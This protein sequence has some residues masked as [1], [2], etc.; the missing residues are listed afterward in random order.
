MHQ[1]LE[2]VAYQGRLEHQPALAASDLLDRPIKLVVPFAP[3]GATDI[4]WR[5][6]ATALGGAWESPW[7]S[8][9]GPAPAPW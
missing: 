4:L 6:Q 7:W 5:L 2:V 3:G 9:A 1:S 8:R